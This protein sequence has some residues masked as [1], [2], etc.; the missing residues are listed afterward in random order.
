MTNA[1]TFHLFSATLREQVEIGALVSF[2]NDIDDGPMLVIRKPI[3]FIA[4]RLAF[5]SR[6]YSWLDNV[7]SP[8]IDAFGMVLDGPVKKNNEPFWLLMLST[9]ERCWFK[10]NAFVCIIPRPQIH[11]NL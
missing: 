1:Q 5:E 4:D 11:S 9:G 6:S 2:V 3:G 7:I 10:R 8:E